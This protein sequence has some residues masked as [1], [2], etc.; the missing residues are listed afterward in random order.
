MPAL[1]EELVRLKVDV[2]ITAGGPAAEA[3]KNAT[4]MVPVV[5]W[6]AG[7]PIA[8]GLIL[9]MAQPGGNMTGVTE[10]STELTAKRLQL[11]KE[12]IPNLAR[13]AIIWNAGDRAMSLRFE[14]AEAAA[15]RFGLSLMRF[16][17]R[18]LDDFAPAFDAMTRERPDGVFMVSDALTRLGEGALFEFLRAN[19]LPSMFEFPPAARDGGL[20]SYGPNLAELAP[21]AAAFVDK[22]LKGAKAG[23]LPVEAPVRWQLI[24]NLK[25]AR[26]IGVTIPATILVLA[27]EV[28][29]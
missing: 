24:V 10:M 29:E 4:T 9:S 26:S 6:G 3:A 17:I 27:D 15:P 8:T 11:F 19:R 22:I 18:A 28:I 2:I 13:V 21:R 12:A 1:A 7:D 20:M 25:T 5:F 14:E 23:D 16:P